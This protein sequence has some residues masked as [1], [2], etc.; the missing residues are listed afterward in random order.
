MPCV[1]SACLRLAQLLV[2]HVARHVCVCVCVCP[3]GSSS[4]CTLH[5]AG[6][7]ARSVSGDGF[8]RRLLPASIHA[9]RWCLTA[10]LCATR[11]APGALWS[12]SAAA[13]VLPGPARVSWACFMSF[14]LH[15][16][17]PRH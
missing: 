14:L 8:V 4:S 2:R 16:T 3:R 5:V 10:A 15:S 17:L 6:K 1:C 11:Q 13:S 7:V 9:S 12:A